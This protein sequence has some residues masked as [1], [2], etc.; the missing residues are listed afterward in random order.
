MITETLQIVNNNNDNRLSAEEVEKLKQ[1][2]KMLLECYSEDVTRQIENDLHSLRQQIRNEYPSAK[3]LEFQPQSFPSP[4][5]EF[6]V[7]SLLEHPPLN[8]PI[9]SNITDNGDNSVKPDPR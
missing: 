9:Q 1:K 7:D 3:F 6:E 5:L 2:L 8:S 4:P